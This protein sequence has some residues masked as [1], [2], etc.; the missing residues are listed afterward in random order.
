MAMKIM[1]R[2]KTSKNMCDVYYIMWLCDSLPS[3]P[4]VSKSVGLAGA[5]SLALL[6]GTLAKGAGGSFEAYLG[7][8]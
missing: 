4:L 5:G 1:G 8:T 6:A 2:L 7:Y 3:Y